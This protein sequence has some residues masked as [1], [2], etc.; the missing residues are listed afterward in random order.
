MAAKKTEIE[1]TPD[2]LAEI[3]RIVKLVTGET[4]VLP[5]RDVK[6]SMRFQPSDEEKTCRFS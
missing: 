6:P 4:Q 2:E 3:D 1:Y 5:A